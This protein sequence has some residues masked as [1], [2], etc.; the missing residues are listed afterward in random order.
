MAPEVLHGKYGKECDVWSLGVIIYQ[1]LTGQYPFDGRTEIEI[2]DKIMLGDFEMP[3]HIS[4]NAKSL[5]DKMIDRKN[6]ERATFRQLLDH[7]WFNHKDNVPI[8]KNVLS[9][10]KS[11]RRHSL[12]T[13]TCISQLIIH[14]APYHTEDLRA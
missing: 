10:L 7:E 12:F 1:M 4:N 8:D 2:R 11:H 5:L 14:L 13:N 9:K 3:D 6:D